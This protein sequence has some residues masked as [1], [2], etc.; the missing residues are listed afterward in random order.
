MM[1]VIIFIVATLSFGYIGSLIVKKTKRVERRIEQLMVKKVPDTEITTERNAPKKTHLKDW[2]KRLAKNVRTTDQKQQ[3]LEHEL[4]SAGI[5]I[6]VEEFITI[7]IALFSITLLL[8]ILLGVQYFFALLI[9]FV[10][11]KLPSIYIKRKKEKRVAASG[12]QLPQALETMASAMKSGFSFMQAMQHVAKEM[13]DPI[14]IEFLRT[15]KEI[16]LG[17]SMD[18]AFDQLLKRLPN[19]DLE[20]VLTAVLIQRST[21]GNLAQILETIHETISD[22]VRMKDELKALTSQGRISALVITLL[23]VGL[24]LLLNLMN[25]EY[26]TPMLQHPLGWA[27]LGGGIVSGTIGW[28]LI[29][30]IVTIEV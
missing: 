22:R 16:N 6:K 15:I 13:P 23:P 14:G 17:I 12:A 3:K 10:S 24:G 27:L 11:W 30:K 26:F 25:P 18:A 7:R 9:G 2:V 8:S 5:P 21:G 4:E 20:M 19:K 29:Q 28:I 1:T